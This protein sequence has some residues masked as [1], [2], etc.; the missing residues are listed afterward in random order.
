MAKYDG[1]DFKPPAGAAKAAQK[2]IDWKK[3]HGDAVQGGTQVGWTRASQLVKGD[4]LSPETVKRMHKFFLRHQKNK[5]V[6][7]KFKDEPWRDNGYV[8]WLIWGGDAGR[9]WA[10]TKWNQME[11][12]DQKTA[13]GIAERIAKKKGL[14]DR[15]RDKRERGEEPA[16]SGDDDYPEEETWKKLTKKGSSLLRSQPDHGEKGHRPQDYTDEELLQ[17]ADHLVKMAKELVN[18]YLNTPPTKLKRDLENEKDPKKRFQ[19]CD[20]LRIRL[21]TIG[22]SRI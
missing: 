15:I 5:A 10:E 14:W 11:K 1:I 12:A 22:R 17:L 16:Q 19:D 2:A 8:A 3:Q 7:P 13:S 6:K 20:Q 21:A 9:S 18:P 4:Q